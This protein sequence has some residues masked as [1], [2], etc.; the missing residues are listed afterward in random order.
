MRLGVDAFIVEGQ[1][2]NFREYNL[3][4]SHRISFDE[5][6]RKNV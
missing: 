3:N 2:P 1:E 5:I 4:I 6:F